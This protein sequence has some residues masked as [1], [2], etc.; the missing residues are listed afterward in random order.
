MGNDTSKPDPFIYDYKLK[1]PIHNS[2]EPLVVIY[3][4]DPTNQNF[5]KLI[6]TLEKNNFNYSIIGHGDEWKHFGTKIVGYRKYYKTLDP[7]QIVIQLDA[8]DVLVNQNYDYFIR[9]ISYF[10]RILEDKII[11]SA[12]KEMSAYMKL[13]PPGTYINKQLLRTKRIKM[14]SMDSINRSKWI[15]E[16]DKITIGPN[17]HVNTGMMIG[18]VKNFLT[19]YEI[20]NISA[21]EISDQ[22]VLSELYL[23]RPE[24]FYLD[25]KSIILKNLGKTDKT[26]KN[27]INAV[28][29]QTPGK[30]WS[31]YNKL[32]RIINGKYQSV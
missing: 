32:F 7:N 12:E 1:Q 20:M 30:N 13:G 3:E 10:S 6:Y 25:T 2:N 16:F 17:N 23:L 18:R 31:I 8:R 9:L 11:V 26:N 5:H 15:K 24:L 19:I 14:G 21:D 22:T 4:T 28:F 27:N 29:I